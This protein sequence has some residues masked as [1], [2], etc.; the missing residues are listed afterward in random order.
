MEDYNFN[1]NAITAPDLL[2]NV[3]DGD[4]DEDLVIAFLDTECADNAIVVLLT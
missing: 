4:D 2:K 3:D 1:E